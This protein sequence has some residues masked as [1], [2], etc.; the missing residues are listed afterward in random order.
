MRCAGPKFAFPMAET[1]VPWIAVF[2][3]AITESL[4][5][6]QNRQQLAINEGRRGY[7]SQVEFTVGNLG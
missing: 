7:V 1:D 6:A 3:P 5:S 4:M 2:D